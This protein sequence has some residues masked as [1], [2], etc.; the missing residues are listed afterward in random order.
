MASFFMKEIILYQ[1]K[2]SNY[3]GGMGEDEHEAVDF[4]AKFGHDPERKRNNR[5]R[6]RYDRLIRHT[7][8][9]RRLEYQGMIIALQS[10][11][12]KSRN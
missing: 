12:E 4:L 10:R 11:L 2:D 5:Q 8:N 3:M 7:L 9:K 6:H 1:A